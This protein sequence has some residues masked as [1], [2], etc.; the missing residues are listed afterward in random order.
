MIIG[1]DVGGTHADGVLLEG[2]RLVAKH[3]VIVD[4]DHLSE[5]VIALLRDLIPE[6]RRQLERIHL[7]S[8]LATNAIVTGNLEPIGMLIQA[9]PG[10]N[11]DFLAQNGRP[12]SLTAS[13]ITAV[14]S[15]ATPTPD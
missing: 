4:Q 9:G 3:K 1:I 12:G 7:S 11:P 6:D 10:I 8:T 13:S 5:T 15:S 14:I 2:T